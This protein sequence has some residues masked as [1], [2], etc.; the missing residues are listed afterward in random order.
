MKKLIFSD[1]FNVFRWKAVIPLALLILAI[2]GIVQANDGDLQWAKTY[3]LN[4][5]KMSLAKTVKVTDD[6]GFII[7]CDFQR[8]DNWFRI[9]V[10]KTDAD[11]DT[12]WTKL[13]GWEDQT[14][15]EFGSLEQTSDGGYIIGG[16]DTY[17]VNEDFTA[18]EAVL[19]KTDAHGDTLWT[20]Y[21]GRD[22]VPYLS[23]NCMTVH[24]TSDSGFII[25]G[26]M[27]KMTDDRPGYYLYDGLV[28]KTDANGDTLWTR[29]YG[30]DI[31][32]THYVFYNALET[33][34]GGFIIGGYK[35]FLDWINPAYQQPFLMK[36]SAEGDSL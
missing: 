17:Y 35:Q 13:Y 6:G 7:G 15:Y 21:Y 27:T 10:I 16:F 9:C 14:H 8:L 30:E 19:I 20:R 36:L 25:G 22:D 11:G 31:D 26:Y 24:E 34:D 28:I 2:P 1:K 32:T 23:Y 29:T 3:E 18:G 4:S 12:L 5:S 33:S